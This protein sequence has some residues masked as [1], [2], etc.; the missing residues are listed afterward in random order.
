MPAPF[1]LLAIALI[2][3]A[4][5]ADAPET[6][7]I[8]YLVREV[9][10]W[11]PENNCYSCHHNGD[12]ARALFAAHAAGFKVPPTAL[13]DTLAWLRRPADWDHNGGEGPFSDKRL[14]RLQ[15][16][17]ALVSAHTSGFEVP[18]ATRAEA[19]QLLVTDQAPDGSWPVEAEDQLGSPA[20]YGRHLATAVAFES[21]T[22]I[23]PQAY[24]PALGRARRYLTSR[25][26]RT[27]LEASAILYGLGPATPAP[28]RDHCLATLEAGR[29]P[30][31]GWGPY[32]NAPPEP[33]DTAV[34]LL[35][36]ARVRDGLTPAQR[37]WIPA[38]RAHLLANR[39]PDGSWPETTRPPGAQS[40]AQHLSTTAWAARAL[41]TTR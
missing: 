23:D 28:L 29:S 15:F 8:A 41:L 16:T 5:P 39:L 27:V 33:F 6:P 2:L 37:A 17:A 4:P 24:E 3:K 20:T 7:T 13:D 19:A 35:A 26:A 31:G 32:I 1:T 21:L 9:P 40:H 18:D 11:R 10:R 38:A 22:A 36:L 14:A 25:P 34:A 12:A 30:D